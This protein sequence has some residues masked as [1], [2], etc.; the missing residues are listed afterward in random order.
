MSDFQAAT[1]GLITAFTLGS[2]GCNHPQHKAPPPQ[3]NTKFVTPS[4]R[5]IEAVSEYGQVTNPDAAAS[6][7]QVAEPELNFSGHKIRVE[8]E[9][10]FA[11]G[12]EVAVIDPG[13]R[14]LKFVE[15]GNSISIIADGTTI[16]SMKR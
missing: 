4:G 5:W 6:L 2:L 3:W 15:Q 10:I 9:R 12:K 16:H 7:L 14:Q 13:V 8:P 1:V 11:D